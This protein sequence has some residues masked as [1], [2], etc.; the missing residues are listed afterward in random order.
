MAKDKCRICGIAEI[1]LP[2]GFVAREQIRTRTHTQWA[3]WWIWYAYDRK[4]KEPLQD[5]PTKLKD[6]RPHQIFREGV[7]YFLTQAG[8]E[9]YLKTT[10][11]AAYRL[12]NVEKKLNRGD[13]A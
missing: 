3:Y 5:V 11:V 8:V 12:R 2:A 4:R 1:E 6:N 10:T 13:A 7:R 9:R